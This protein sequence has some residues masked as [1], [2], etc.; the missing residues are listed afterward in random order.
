MSSWSA[1][2]LG[3]S[4][5]VM[6][7]PPVTKHIV[8]AVPSIVFSQSIK[9]QGLIHSEQSTQSH[10]P[11]HRS[12]SVST[13]GIIFMGT[14]H[15]GGH[16]SSVKLGTLL[17]KIA[18][19]FVK[20]NSS[21]LKNLK[22]GSE[23]LEMQLA[24][25]TPL[26]SKYDTTFA[27][28]EYSTDILGKSIMVSDHCRTIQCFYLRMPFLGRSSQFSRCSWRAQRGNHYYTR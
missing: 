20:V 16:N 25:Y 1:E 14:P 3:H 27:Y 13:R 9:C 6:V 23:W 28:E 7:Q 17:L 22:P 11:E 21:L 2:H 26:S 4:G 12:I 10:L 18:S 15:R 5:W 24:Q 8:A 19:I